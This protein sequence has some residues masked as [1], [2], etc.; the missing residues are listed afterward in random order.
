MLKKGLIICLLFFLSLCCYFIIKP[1]IEAHY[2]NGF[3]SLNKKEVKYFLNTDFTIQTLADDLLKKHVIENKEAFLSIAKKIN[4][5]SLTIAKGKYIIK[6]KTSY[7]ELAWG[8][9]KNKYGE[10]N[11]EKKVN[12]TIYSRKNMEMVA[13]D[14]QKCIAVDSSMLLKLLDSDSILNLLDLEN[15]NDIIS[16]FSPGIYKMYYDS[17]EKK[18]VEFF[19]RIQDEFWNNKR[20]DLIYKV[21]L[22]SKKEIITLASIVYSEQSKIKE[23]WPVIA[24]VYLNRLKKGMKLESDPTFKFCWGNKLDG[25]SRLLNKHREIDCP[26]NTYKIKGLPPGPIC[27]TPLEVI[28]SVLNYSK[29]SKYIFMCAKPDYSSRHNFASTLNQHAKNANKYQKW[30]AN[31]Q[32]SK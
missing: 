12:L 29:N 18:V 4:L 20:K 9:K 10:G 5:N 27:V 2:L 24:S 15:K 8:F 25:V 7:K 28:D 26:Y 19:K 30:I 17:D 11:S 6:P 14:I 16:I 23:E 1:K 31:E 22:K 21:G 32:K 3:L 13:M